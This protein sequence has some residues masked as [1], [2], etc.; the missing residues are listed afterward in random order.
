[1]A[2]GCADLGG[3]LDVFSV[4]DLMGKDPNGCGVML[5]IGLVMFGLAA[6]TIKP[7][8]PPTPPLTERVKREVEKRVPHPINNWKIK[9]AKKKLKEKKEAAR[10]ERERRAKLVEEEDVETPKEDGWW[11]KTKD[12]LRNKLNKDFEER[13]P[14]AQDESN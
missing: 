13:H 14:D 1:M 3:C 5:L 4:G 2:D 6:T 8:P 12:K 9:R 7:Q 10:K 11:V